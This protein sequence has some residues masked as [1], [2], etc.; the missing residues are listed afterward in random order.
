MESYLCITQINDFIFC[1]RSIYFHNIYHANYSTETYHKTWQKKGCAVHA[2]IS[3]KNTTRKNIIQELA[4]YSE[5]YNIFGKID[6]YD[7]N[8]KELTERKYSVTRIYD[9]FR[10]QLYAQYYC[11]LEMGY[12]IDNMKIYS[13]KSNKNYPIAIPTLAEQQEFET[14]L[15]QIRNYSLLEPFSQNPKK[16]I[17]CIYN[18]LCDIY[19]GE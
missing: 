6:T 12:Q 2:S 15:Q 9:G 14:V 7:I 11:M 4:V 13:K 19:T 10:Y 17:N 18:P 1:P 16:C 8:K 5:K 3:E